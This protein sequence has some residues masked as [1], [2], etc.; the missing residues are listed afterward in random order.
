MGSGT[1]FAIFPS[2]PTKS[3]SLKD[4]SSMPQSK[5]S[6]ALIAQSPPLTDLFTA[7]V[8]VAHSCPAT[9]PRLTPQ[10]VTTGH[11][12]D[13]LALPSDSHALIKRSMKGDVKRKFF[14]CSGN[15]EN[16]LTASPATLIVTDVVAADA[17]CQLSQCELLQRLI[18][19]ISCRD[20]AQMATMVLFVTRGRWQCQVVRGG[21]SCP[22]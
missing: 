19:A 20:A 1:A 22:S 18:L 7:T 14:P 5:N 16:F 13:D 11:S 17:L 21:L 6:P 2:G 12:V 15:Q 10:S 9:F 8:E 3:T 4:F